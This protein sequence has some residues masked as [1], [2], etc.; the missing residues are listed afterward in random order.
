[1]FG[2]LCFVEDGMT[3]RSFED[4]RVFQ[5][6][7]KLFDELWEIVGSWG[8]FEKDTVGKQL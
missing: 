5:L 4:L 7:E 3:F 8:Y 2:I 1:V 6:S